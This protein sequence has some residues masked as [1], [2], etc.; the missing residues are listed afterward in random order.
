MLSTVGWP[1][2][3]VALPLELA[4]LALAAKFL[5]KPSDASART[6]WRMSLIHL[7][8]LLTFLLLTGS[9]FLR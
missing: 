4:H 9:R 6:L 1:Y 7:P 2:V 8:V 3:T 5:S